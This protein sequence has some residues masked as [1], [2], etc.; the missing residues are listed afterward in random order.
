M[1]RL[2]LSRIVI[3]YWS[4]RGAARVMKGVLA[5]VLELD[6]DTCTIIPRPC[7]P[8]RKMNMHMSATRTFRPDATRVGTASPSYSGTS[9]IF[10]S[11]RNYHSVYRSCLKDRAKQ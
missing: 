3:H 9:G 7:T 10:R 4:F 6:P 2:F 5:C 1:L 11:T 8:S